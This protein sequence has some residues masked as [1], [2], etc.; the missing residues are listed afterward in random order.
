MPHAVALVGRVL[1]S[2]IFIKAGIGK[3]AAPDGTIQ[4]IASHGMPLPQEAYI[5]AVTVELGGGLALLLGWQ[6]RL[7]GALLALFCLVTAWVFHGNFADHNM[8]IH[9]MKN[10]AIA[11]GLLQVAAFGAGAFSLDAMLARRRL[12]GF[13]GSRA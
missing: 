1:L 10:V 9:F 6:A 3:I 5:V 4:L 7:A 12:E 11:G 2:L 13:S 8:Q